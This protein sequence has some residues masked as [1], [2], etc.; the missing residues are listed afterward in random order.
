MQVA[1]NGNIIF[2]NRAELNLITKQKVYETIQDALK[3]AKQ[4]ATREAIELLIPIACTAIYEAY[5]FGE[6]RQ[7]AFLEYMGRHLECI[8]DGVTTIDQYEDWCKD[9]K[10]K[11]FKVAEVEHEIKHNK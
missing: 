9:N 1:K 2:K 8:Q 4:D 5:G 3:K 7:E 6:K 10:I 11:Y